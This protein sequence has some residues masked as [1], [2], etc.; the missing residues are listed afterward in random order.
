MKKIL[1]IANIRSGKAVIKKYMVDMI[2]YYNT[3]DCEV[4]TYISQYPGHVTEIVASIGSEFDNIICCGG[5][6][7]FNETISGVMELEKKPVIG[8]VPCGSTNDFANTAGISTTIDK[9]YKLAITGKDFIIDIGELNGKYFTYVSA[10][11][12]F[13]NVTYETPQN[14]KNMLG[15][16]AYVLQGVKQVVSIPSYKMKIEYDD[17]VIEGNFVLGFVANSKKV[18]GFK[19]FDDNEID[20]NDGV[21]EVMLVREIKNINDVKDFMSCFL[22]SKFDKDLFCIL[23]TSHIKFTSEEEI[24][25]TVDGEFGGKYKCADININHQAIKI[26]I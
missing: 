21:F 15:H 14:M 2:D 25:W 7:T 16:L 1:L 12:I 3:E 8:Y 5:D 24:S 19:I 4:T 9:A 11:G 20:L 22:L 23:K 26:L 17:G 18:G 13:T 10:F 6:G